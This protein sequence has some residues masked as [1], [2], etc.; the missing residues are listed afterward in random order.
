M[1]CHGYRPSSKVYPCVLTLTFARTTKI[2]IPLASENMAPLSSK[3]EDALLTSVLTP[4]SDP[5]RTARWP[6]SAF[7]GGVQS[8]CWASSGCTSVMTPRLQDYHMYISG[9]TRSTILYNR[10]D[11]FRYEGPPGST[12]SYVSNWSHLSDLLLTL[13]CEQ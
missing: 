13:L 4:P 2:V 3:T 10:V 6:F 7:T 11:H 1:P 8:G 9:S 5:N 12:F